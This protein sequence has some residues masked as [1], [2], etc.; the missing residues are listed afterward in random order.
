MIHLPTG[1]RNG[2]QLAA[3]GKAGG[4]ETAQIS[5]GAD[6]RWLDALCIQRA[7]SILPA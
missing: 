1:S 6:P 3:N 4:S 5:R 2:D 7:A